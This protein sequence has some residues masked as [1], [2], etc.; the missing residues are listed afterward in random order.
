VLNDMSAMALSGKGLN[1]A[2]TMVASRLVEPSA[3]YH[4]SDAADAHGDALAP[5]APVTVCSTTP[6]PP[7]RSTMAA[8]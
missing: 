7:S 5:R 3:K 2:S 6:W 1:R 4:R 8:A